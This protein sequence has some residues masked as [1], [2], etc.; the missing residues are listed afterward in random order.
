MGG[1]IERPMFCVG[2]VGCILVVSSEF[3]DRR[4]RNTQDSTGARADDADKAELG[5]G[6]GCVGLWP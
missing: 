6:E 4:S 5:S 3:Q 2:R 1:R